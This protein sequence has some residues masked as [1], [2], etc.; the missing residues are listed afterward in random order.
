MKCFLGMQKLLQKNPSSSLLC[1]SATTS[2]LSLSCKEK[3]RNCL[4]FNSNRIPSLFLT[5]KPYT[6]LSMPIATVGGGCGSSLAACVARKAIVRPTLPSRF[7]SNSYSGCRC[8]SD[9]RTIKTPLRAWVVARPAWN[10]TA[11]GA[12]PEG[13]V[14]TAAAAAVEGGKGCDGGNSEKRGKNEKTSEEKTGRMN[15]R[16][17]GSSEVVGNADLLTIPG[18]GPKNLRKLVE[19]G[20]R[21]VAELKQLYKDKVFL[22]FM[23]IYI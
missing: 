10:H 18:V 16:Q 4:Y 21:G 11:A 9:N 5:L 14:T 23:Y 19:K 6:S 8:A 3:P 13:N 22:L 2:F 20:L 15:R 7:S 12:G 17:R 1:T